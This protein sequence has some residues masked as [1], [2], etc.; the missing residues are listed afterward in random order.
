MKTKIIF[1]SLVSILF[2]SGCGDM[3]RTHMAI[4]DNYPSQFRYE[5]YEK[6]R[7]VETRKVSSG[8]DLYNKLFDWIKNKHD[9]W[10]K[11]YNTYAPKNL[12]VSHRMKVLL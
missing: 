12:F 1:I 6:G 5:R 11:D 7:L 9:G 3:Q 4:I 10:K 8:D 2:I